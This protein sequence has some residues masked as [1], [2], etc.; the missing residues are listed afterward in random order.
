MTLKLRLPRPRFSLRTLFVVITLLCATLGVNLYKAQQQKAAVARVRAEMGQC[1]YDFE[2][3]F[4]AAQRK[5]DILNGRQSSFGLRNRNLPSP[6]P[7]WLVR[8]FGKDFFHN[9][10]EAHC[11]S[12]RK[13]DNSQDLS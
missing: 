3:A 9:V 7:A 6:W 10:T 1:T 12:V 8:M 5:A 13:E 11:G 4:E 2:A